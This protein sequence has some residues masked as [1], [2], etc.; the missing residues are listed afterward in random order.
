M[1]RQYTCNVKRDRYLCKFKYKGIKSI[2]NEDIKLN[3]MAS[4]VSG[5]ELTRDG[6][7]FL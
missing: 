2:S 7:K 5:F 4:D 6:K 1:I 3:D